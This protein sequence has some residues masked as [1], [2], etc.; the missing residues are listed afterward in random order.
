MHVQTF[1]CLYCRFS[2]V[3]YLNLRVVFQLILSCVLLGRGAIE[4]LGGHRRQPGEPIS[5]WLLRCWDNGAGRQ[6]L[7]GH[8]AQQLGSLAKD[9]EIERGIG[10]EGAIC[11]LWRRLLSSVRARYPFKEDLVNSPG[12]WTTADEGIQ[13]LR[14]LAVLEIV[15]RDLKSDRVPE[16]PED[17]SCTMAMWR[18]VVQS[19]PASYSS[20]LVSLYHP[21]MDTPTIEMASSWLR[22]VEETLG[23]SSSLQASSPAFRGSPRDRSSPSPVRGKGSPKRRPRGELWFFLRDQG[24]DMRKWVGEPT[25]KLEARVRELRGKKAVKRSP[26]KTA[27]VVATE[28]QEGNQRFPR[29]KRTKITSFHPGEGTSDLA[30]R[31]SDSEYSDQE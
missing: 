25:F 4:W 5:A 28:R 11:S 26:K 12:K 29:H 22:N 20:S 17:A 23:T 7:E 18:K 15:Y 8:E 3:P 27:S 6:Q 31:R 14:E 1:A 9:R 24:E 19:A 16:D 2:K 21:Q 13:Y 30:S 10:K